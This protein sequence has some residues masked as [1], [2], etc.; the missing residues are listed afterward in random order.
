VSTVDF[1][2]KSG[3]GERLKG[4]GIDFSFPLPLAKDTFARDLV[5]YGIFFYLEVPNAWV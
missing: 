1:L 4:K 3:K 2:Q 5:F